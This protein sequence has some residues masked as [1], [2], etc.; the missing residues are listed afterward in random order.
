MSEDFG[1]AYWEEHY[2]AGQRHDPHGDGHHPPQ[3]PLLQEAALLTAGTALDAG[4]G[5]GSGAIW[6]ASRG[7][8]VTAVD[9]ATTALDRARR[10]AAALGADVED[11][12][13]W[14]HA[15]LTRWTPSEA[16]YDLVSALYVHV[17]ERARESFYRRL[18]AAVAPG[19]TLLVAGHHPSDLETT[20]SRGS[21]P[22]LYLTAD[23]VAA[24]LDPQLW[25]IIV[26]ET[27]PRRTRDPEGQEITIN[28]TVLRARKA[29]TESSGPRGPEAS[30]A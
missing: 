17:P 15:D 5:E 30:G 11:R 20:M 29:A 24:L 10:R 25:E 9:V 12:I 23:Q 21:A 19:G 22:E 4:C 1:S 28:E 26:A 16:Q 14:R 8:R 13:E 2:R 3:S 7:W 27:R 6:L 18:A